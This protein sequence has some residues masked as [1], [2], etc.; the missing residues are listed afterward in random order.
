MHPRRALLAA[1]LLFPAF[2]L[3][4]QTTV[5]PLPA[6]PKHPVVDEYNGVK[7]T[8]NYRWLEDGKSP[9]VIAWIAAENAHAHAILDDLPIR[10]QIRAYFKKLD[11]TSS[12]AFY[13]LEIRGGTLFAM[14]FEPGKQQ[15]VLVTL[16]SPDDPASKH[17]VLDPA[18]IDSTNSTAIQFYA[19]SQ[20]GSKVAVSLAQGGSE[21]GSV[22]V[23][24]VATGQALSN[25]VPHTTAIGGGSVIW[26]AD[27]SG[28][29]Y[30]HY[31]S[32]GERPKDDLNFFQ[33]IYFHKVGHGP[34]G[35]HLRHRQGFSPGSPRPY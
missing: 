19:P 33:Q 24:D 1:L 25:V 2:A 32:V 22:H 6:T 34:D 4:W 15:G 12:P 27:G 8:D 26:S 35:G 29:Y 21:M 9:E 11:D 14:N 30:T 17:V 31:P 3:A 20:D 7:V 28:F 16:R 13:A 10:N 23:Y 18:Q 5:P